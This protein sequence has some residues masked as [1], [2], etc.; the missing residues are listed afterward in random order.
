MAENVVVAVD[1]GMASNAALDWAIDRARTVDMH[2]EITTVVD[3]DWI[4][5]VD[6]D[7]VLL[8]HDKVVVEAAKRVEFSDV[9]VDFSTSVHHAR[10][11]AGM[12][13]ALLGCRRR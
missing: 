11:V 2:L 5:R 10:P 1:G 12:V 6:P 7:P 4:P 9:P 8:E 13:D 3:T